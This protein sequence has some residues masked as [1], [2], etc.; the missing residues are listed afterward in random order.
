M[1]GSSFLQPRVATTLKC[2]CNDS[3][4]GVLRVVRGRSKAPHAIIYGIYTLQR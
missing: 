2:T 1:H 4:T 3:F